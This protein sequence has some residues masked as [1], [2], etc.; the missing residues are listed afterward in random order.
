MVFQTIFQQG[1]P[2]VDIAETCLHHPDAAFVT[3]SVPSTMTTG[4]AFMVTLVMRNTSAA[5]A[6]WGSDPKPS[7]IVAWMPPLCERIRPSVRNRS[8]RPMPA[9]ATR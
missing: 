9:V 6:I 2:P 7:C 3:Q 1:L 8:T 5:A 4:Q